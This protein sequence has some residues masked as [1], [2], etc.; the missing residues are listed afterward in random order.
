MTIG[1]WTGI[2]IFTLKVFLPLAIIPLPLCILADY[3]VERLGS[4]AGGFLSGWS[5]RRATL[6]E[7]LT[8]DL[9]K[10]R[11][12]KREGR[13]EEALAIINSV[14]EKDP[15]FPDALFLKARILWEGFDNREGA[16]GCLKKV[17]QV[18]PKNETLHRWAINYYN[19]IT[20]TEE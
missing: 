5:S 20:K 15:Q 19:E 2:G 11:Y 12:S 3:V 16:Q 17:V 9:Q 1:G 18:A 6:R 14:L 13:F 8:A 7:S 10:A 4:G